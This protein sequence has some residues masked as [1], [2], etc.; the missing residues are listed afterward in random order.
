MPYKIAMA[1][2]LKLTEKKLIAMS[3]EMVAAI[4]DYR[5]YHRIDTESEAIR[6]LIQAGLDLP[7]LCIDLLDA[8]EAEGLLDTGDLKQ[9]VEALE[10]YL[11]TSRSDDF[12]RK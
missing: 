3:P 9:P 11:G 2:P 10:T 4:K 6:Q 7:R 1:K 12:P 8:I 5:F